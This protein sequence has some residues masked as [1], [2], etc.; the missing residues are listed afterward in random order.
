VSAAVAVLMYHRLGSGALAGRETGEEMYA[1]APELFEEHLA[2]IAESGRPVVGLDGLLQ[3]RAGVAGPA[4]VLTFD[5]GNA[6]DHSQALPA[7]SRRGW[8]GIFFV[9][10]AWTGTPGYMD[11]SQLRELS[12]AGMTVGA[13]GFDHTWL[14]TLDDAALRRQMRDARAALSDV[15]GRPPLAISLPGGSGGARAVRIARE[16]GFELVA[17]SEPHLAWP[18]RSLAPMPRFAVRCDHGA[19]VVGAL[20]AQRRSVILRWRLRHDLLQL[21]RSSLGEGLYAR[22]RGRW[23]AGRGGGESEA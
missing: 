20:A 9:V 2:A 18:A 6:T 15:L 13:H 11:Q 3:R 22:L 19:P 8:S 21:L 17:T 23:A 5:D 10:P 12:Q 7:L 16:E 14:A 1:V 4:V